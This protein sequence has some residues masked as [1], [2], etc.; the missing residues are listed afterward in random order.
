M[1]FG[2]KVLE[3]NLVLHTSYVGGPKFGRFETKTE[4]SRDYEVYKKGKSLWEDKMG[5]RF[6]D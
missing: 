2:N 6:K 4:K 5:S 3:V 1:H